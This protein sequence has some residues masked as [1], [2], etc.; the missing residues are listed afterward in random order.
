MALRTPQTITVTTKIMDTTDFV[1]LYEEYSET[2]SC[3]CTII[4]IPYKTIVSNEVQFHSIC[5]SDFITR[6]WAESLYRTDRSQLFVT[7]FR[8]T[9]YAQVRHRC[10]HVHL[11]HRCFSLYYSLIFA[12]YLKMLFQMLWTK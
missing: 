9:A 7:D 1:Q 4:N 6:R 10:H 12:K 2:L 5:S 11:S 8:K 3:P